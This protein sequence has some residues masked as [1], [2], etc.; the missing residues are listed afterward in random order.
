[1]DIINLIQQKYGNTC[2]LCAPLSKEQRD[3]A[4]N[5][6]SDELLKVLTVSNEINEVTTHS[7]TN[8]GNPFVID[9]I[10]YSFDEIKAETE[11]YLSIHG[12]EGVVFSGNGAG[13]SFI[14]KSD[15]KIYLLEFF[16]SDEELCA[17]S[18]SEFFKQYQQ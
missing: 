9:L 14:Q 5:M 10:V 17:E 8:D 1:M 7:N 15:G 13:G 2:Q 4:K 6:L 3:E 16:D 12:R 11:N 18:L